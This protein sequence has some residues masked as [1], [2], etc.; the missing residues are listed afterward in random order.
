M[1]TTTI[2]STLT[3]IAIAWGAR[4]LSEFGKKIA[5]IETLLTGADGSNGINGETKA[6]RRD[7]DDHSLYLERLDGRV[8]HLESGR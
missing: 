8:G 6:L 5:R 3:V 7:V 2:L 4:S 1:E